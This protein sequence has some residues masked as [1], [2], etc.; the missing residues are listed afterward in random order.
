[1]SVSYRST[2]RIR[3]LITHST[4]LA[5][6]SSS[7]N[8][9]GRFCERSRT[10]AR[11][12]E[13]SRKN[14]GIFQVLLAGG[15]LGFPEESFFSA[16]K[17]PFYTG[18]RLNVVSDCIGDI[19]GL[20]HRSPY[21]KAETRRETLLEI[22][23]PQNIDRKQAPDIRVP[24]GYNLACA[25][26]KCMPEKFCKTER[27][28]R[29]AINDAESD[30][31]RRNIRVLSNWRVPGCLSLL[32]S[33][34]Y[35]DASRRAMEYIKTGISEKYMSRLTY[36]FPTIIPLLVPRVSRA[37]VRICMKKHKEVGRASG[38]TRNCPRGNVLQ[39]KKKKKRKGKMSN[40]HVAPRH[41]PWKPS[42]NGCSV[43]RPGGRAGRRLIVISRDKGFH[44]S[45]DRDQENEAF[46]KGARCLDFTPTLIADL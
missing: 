33:L 14:L 41:C 35:D 43:E 12:I 7:S 25:C 30:A 26:L 9:L 29:G 22:R 40:T 37:I 24:F 5:E 36:T 34:P 39:Q 20:L 19:R 32:I 28:S 16:F 18:E 46:S 6:L 10:N 38:V 8:S 17:S 15:I 27:I 3:R 2:R 11:I 45:R 31:F 4:D 21:L 23:N 1:M 42:D 13:K 44:L